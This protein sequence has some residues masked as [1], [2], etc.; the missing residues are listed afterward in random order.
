MFKTLAAP[1]AVGATAGA[2]MAATA[3]AGSAAAG[4]VHAGT[5]ES[6]SPANGAQTHSATKDSK[7][8]HAPSAD[9]P[10]P[11]TFADA[12]RQE[13][14]EEVSATASAEAV[15]KDSAEA[16]L[17]VAETTTVSTA[18][19]SE[20]EEDMAKESGKNG[21]LNGHQTKADAVETAPKTED[22][23]KAMAAAADGAHSGATDPSAI[24]NI[25]DSV[26]ADLR[27]KIVE[28]IAKKLA[29]K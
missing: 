20:G 8:E 4:V 14:E 6:P 10:E 25:V 21:K 22:A 23:P 12:V 2:A 11:V 27:P 24:A 18:K 19:A 9:E 15:S 28:E 1:A 5:Q 17:P 7:G 13:K 26:L 16:G 3:A 29:G